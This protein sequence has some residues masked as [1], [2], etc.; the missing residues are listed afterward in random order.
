MK[1]APLPTPHRFHGHVVVIPYPTRGHV[2][3]MMS[4]CKLIASSTTNSNTNHDDVLLITVVVTQ[5]WLSY[6]G[7]D[8]K[9]DNIR[10]ATIPNGVV[11]LD[12]QITADIPGFFHAVVTNMEAPFEEILD[13]LEPPVTS[14]IGDVELKFPV[15]V[16]RRRNIPVAV[17]WTMSASFYLMLHRLE[18]VTR[19]RLLK[20]DLLGKVS[21]PTARTIV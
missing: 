4:L 5:E 21:Y 19:N 17:L 9:H 2:N 7:S 16:G 10:F 11:P 15:A 12:T 14:I 20:V 3:P 13:R 8:P 1:Q 18:S 6:I